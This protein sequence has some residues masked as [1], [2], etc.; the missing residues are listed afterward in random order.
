MALSPRD[1]LKNLNEVAKEFLGKRKDHQALVE[2]V[3]VLEVLVKKHEK[4]L[5]NQEA[6]PGPKD[7]ESK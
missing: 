1:A 5:T 4:E 6:K 3:D 7:A 2:S